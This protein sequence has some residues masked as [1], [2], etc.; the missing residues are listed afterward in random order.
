MFAFEFNRIRLPAHELHIFRVSIN[1]VIVG[2][3]FGRE[4]P[5]NKPF[6]FEYASTYK[7]CFKII[8]HFI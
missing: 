3:I 8:R 2:G 7:L 6:C 4:L 5:K 1:P